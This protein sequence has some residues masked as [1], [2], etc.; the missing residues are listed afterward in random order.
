[1]DLPIRADRRLALDARVTIAYRDVAAGSD[2][3]PAFLDRLGLERFHLISH[4][5]GAKT[6]LS[7]RS[8]A[9]AR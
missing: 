4:D 9:R 7:S 3:D 1:M 5:T 6:I 8:P 2:D